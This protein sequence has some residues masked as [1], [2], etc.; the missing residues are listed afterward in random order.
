MKNIME[1]EVLVEEIDT[2]EVLTL[3]HD[4]T[5][6]EMELKEWIQSILKLMLSEI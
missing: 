1:K 6:M 5:K 2:S 3:V 4:S